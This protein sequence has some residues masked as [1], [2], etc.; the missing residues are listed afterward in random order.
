[1]ENNFRAQEAYNSLKPRSG[2]LYMVNKSR[3]MHTKAK[4]LNKAENLEKK[5]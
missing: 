2:S 3:K 4:I 1:V 5:V